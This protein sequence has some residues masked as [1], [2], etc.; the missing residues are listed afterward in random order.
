MAKS[1]SLRIE[2]NYGGKKRLIRAEPQKLVKLL[3]SIYMGHYKNN[4]LIETQEELRQL[5]E[6]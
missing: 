4:E 5:N 2:I 6:N 1:E 3:L